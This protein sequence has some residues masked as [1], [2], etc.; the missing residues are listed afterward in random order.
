M[1]D[2]VLVQA[3]RSHEVDLY[4]IPGSEAAQQRRTVA[5]HVLR[6]REDRR[7]VVTRMRVFRR[8]E[9]VVVVEL[10]HRDAVRPC[11]PLRTRAAVESTAEDRRA[12]A[13]GRDDVIERLLTCGAHRRSGE[14]CGSH[15]R[16]VDD[17][18]DDHAHDVGFDVD[19][20]GGDLGDA[21]SELLLSRE[22]LLTAVDPDVVSDGHAAPRSV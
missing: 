8:K 18:V 4:F 17:A 11:P 12:V 10:T 2:L 16:V 20:V 15:R 14:R 19:R 3:D 21:P 1:V 7:D 6:D 5:A 9:R 13:V 22:L